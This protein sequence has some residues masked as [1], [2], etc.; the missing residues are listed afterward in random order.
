M[1]KLILVTCLLF[2]A[3]NSFS[4]Y[5]IR[6]KKNIGVIGMYNFS[7]L[8]NQTDLTNSSTSM[9]LG[10]CRQFGKYFVPEIGMTISTPSIVKTPTFESLFTGVQIRKNLFKINQR[11]VGAKCKSEVLECFLVP[12]YTYLWNMG[13]NIDQS[14]VSI[15]Y[16]LGLYHLESGGSKQSRAWV[17]KIECYHR[18]QLGSRS[19][20]PH[21]FG[22]GL[23]IQHF[24]TYD[25]LR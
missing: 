25:F 11:K 3:E 22:I 9:Q 7:N 23:R 15:R 17:T 10:L 5:Y 18:Y 24:K 4:Q 8:S 6:T 16:G 1:K 20:F 2:I 12:E 21:E 19:I 14:K 13:R